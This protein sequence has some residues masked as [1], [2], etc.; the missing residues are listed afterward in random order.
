MDAGNACADYH[1]QV[2]CNIKAHRVQVDEI[3]SFCYAKEKNVPYAKAAKGFPES[4]RSKGRASP[5]QDWIDWRGRLQPVAA[6]RIET[7]IDR[8]NRIAWLFI[9]SILYIDVRQESKGR[10]G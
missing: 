8:I 2:V 10:H 4:V 7:W 5:W 6:I 9:L 1:D 3:W